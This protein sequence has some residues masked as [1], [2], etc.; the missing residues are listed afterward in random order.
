MRIAETERTVTH[1]IDLRP[2]ALLQVD[3]HAFVL[4][5]FPDSLAAYRL[6]RKLKPVVL[7]LDADDLAEYL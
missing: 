7:D 1:M 2:R 5:V 4:L 3:A 6:G